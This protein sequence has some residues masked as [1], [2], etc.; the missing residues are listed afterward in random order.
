MTPYQKMRAQAGLGKMICEH[1]AY[2]GE[3][4]MTGNVIS[5]I[6]FSAY[7]RP[8]N[9]RPDVAPQFW[10]KDM[11]DG[12]LT[13]YD[14][15]NLPSYIRPWFKDRVKDMAQCSNKSLIVYCVRYYRKRNEPIVIGYIVTD[16]DYNLKFNTYPN[17]YK[18]QAVMDAFIPLVS[19]NR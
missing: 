14:L 1:K 12:Y 3:I 5:D 17:I 6:Q 13:A 19:L 7:I 11:K 4:A 15:K 16:S 9:A 8:F 18:H 10:D 2:N